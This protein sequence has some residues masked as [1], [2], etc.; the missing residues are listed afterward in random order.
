MK[1][2]DQWNAAAELETGNTIACASAAR[3]GLR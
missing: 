1:Q 2:Q 3:T